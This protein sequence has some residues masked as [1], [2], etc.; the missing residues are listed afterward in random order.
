[1]A[2]DLFRTLLQEHTRAE[3]QDL[4]GQIAS[5]VHLIPYDVTGTLMPTAHVTINNPTGIVLICNI[6]IAANNQ[7]LRHAAVGSPVRMKRSRSGRLEIIGIDKRATGTLFNYVLNISTAVLTSGAIT[8]SGGID[9][10]GNTSSLSF[11][12]LTLGELASVTSAGFGE[13]PL[14]ATGIFNGSSTL[15]GLA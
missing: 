6:P 1:M 14:Q 4:I 9:L 2:R 5:P 11:R 12:P 8:V 10:A 3:Q 13:T 15:L 7:E